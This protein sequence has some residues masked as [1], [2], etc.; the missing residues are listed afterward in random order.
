MNLLLKS[1][2]KG[3]PTAQILKSLISENQI[4]SAIFVFK[5]RNPPALQQRLELTLEENTVLAK[6]TA[7]RNFSRLPF[8]EALMLSCFGE[9]RDFSR[10]LR[11]AMFHQPHANSL[12]RI[13]RDEVL[14]D[15]LP[16]LMDMQPTG[17][18][19][20]FISKIELEGGI[21]KQLPLLDFHCPESVENDRLVSEVC[22]RLFQNT[23]LVFS[24]G[25]S[26]HALGLE[27]LDELGFR[28][29]LARSLFFAPIVDA[30][31]V[32]HQLLEGECALRLSN[33]VD[34]PNRP[35]LKFTLA[36]RANE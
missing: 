4:I 1:A 25:K 31:Y 6:A 34:K 13:S 20:S 35:H 11:E 24:S 9:Q 7:L 29:F 8:W 10:L 18:H 30:R 19:L 16:E 21:T 2:L 32:A 3:M 28:K 17:H 26:Y 27:P 15:R 23:T 33:S 12:L 36:I 22:K 14:V 5:Y